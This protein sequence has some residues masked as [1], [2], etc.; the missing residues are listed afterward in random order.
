MSRADT[1]HT[2][3]N[4][5]SIRIKFPGP[6][7]TTMFFKCHAMVGYYYAKILRKL[8]G[9]AL[10][11]SHRHPS[12]KLEAGTDFINSSIERHSFC[13]YD[14]SILNTDIAA[15]CSIGNKVTIGGVNHPLSFVST[16]PVFLSH[17]DSVKTK[18][19]RH[20]YLPEI[21]T[22]IGNDVWI[23]AGAYVKAGV[24]IGDGAA[25][26][27]AAVVTRDVPAYAIVAG[28]PARLIRMRF[29]EHIV[30]A[31]MELKWW[32]LSD[33]ELKALGPMFHSPETLLKYSEIKSKGT[34]T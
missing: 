16:S 1:P 15:F 4:N 6:F 20:D 33:E 26:G 28:N 25:I 21:R 19:A 7:V 9:M 30:S 3:T 13:G 12:A 24:T 22:R 29:A 5:D 8:R 10:L 27:M 18:L 2:A 31:L 34:V 14:C 32:L 17:K 11:N 23:G